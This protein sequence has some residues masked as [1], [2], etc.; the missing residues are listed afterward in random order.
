FVQTLVREGA[1][2]YQL[3]D[4]WA[5]L[6]DQE[7]YLRW[8]QPHHQAIFAEARGVPRILF[9]KEC[10][11]LE[12]MTQTGAEVISLG[13][14]HNLAEARAQYPHLVFQGNVDEEV[15]RSGTQDDVRRATKECLK[16]GG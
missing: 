14:T 8:A 10:P 7:E 3:F 16:A 13:T 12:Q 2:A 6:L 4:S 11:F 15:L 5:G 9:V 1:D